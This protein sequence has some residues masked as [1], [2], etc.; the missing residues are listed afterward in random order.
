[1]NNILELKNILIVDDDPTSAYLLSIILEKKGYKIRV[2]HHAGAVFNT[3]LPDLIL[4]D[5]KMPEMSG[6]ELCQQLKASEQ[7]QPIPVIFIS[8]LEETADKIKGFQVGGVDYITKPF[9]PEEVL[10]RVKTHLTISAMQKQL[11]IQNRQLQ[12]EI[13]ARQ[14]FENKLQK[15]EEHYHLLSDKL[16]VRV[17]ERIRA[18]ARANK[19]LQ[20][21]IDERKQAKKAL[22][23]SEILYRSFTDD[24]L[25][26]L[27]VGIFILDAD[28]KVV[29]INR[30]IERY[31]GL[32]REA[33]IGKDKRQLIQERIQ[34]IFVDPKKFVKKVFATYD[35]NTYVE[36]FEC[37]VLSSG[38]R[39]ERWLEH[40][41]MPIYSGIY[42]G[43]RIEQYYDITDRK[44][45]DTALLEKTAF[46][47]GILRYSINQAI[48]ATDINF[49]ITYYNP[50]AEKIFGYTAKEAIGKT[51]MEI[52]TKEKV[53]H[54]RFQRAIK[55]VQEE[56]EYHYTV[57]NEKEDGTHYVDSRVSGILDKN[58]EIIGF[59]LLSSDVTERKRNEAALRESRE[60]LHA[61]LNNSA[62][63]IFLKD[64]TG[65]YLFINKRFE[66]LFLISNEEIS[67]KTDYDFFPKENAEL[68]VSHDQEVIKSQSLLK[69]EEV[70]PQSDGLHTYLSVKFPLYDTKG[71]I[72]AVCGMA[73]DITERKKIEEELIQA[74][75]T[76][77]SASQA[78]SEFLANMSHEIRT[79]MNAIIVLTQLM[80]KTE[81]TAKQRDFLTD[82]KSS[83]QALL[84]I[85][86]DILDFSKIEAGKL[87][88]ESVN[89][90]LDN[91]LNR[92]S[93]MLGMKIEEK[94]LEL[95]ITIDTDIPH[96]LVGD[97]L[98]L[99]QILVNLTNNAIKFTENGKILIKIRILALETEKVKLH[100]S[101]Q[102]TGIGISQEIIAHL[103][104]AFTQA[105]GSTT[106]E[107]GGT[108][109]GLAI[110]K[111]LVE[112]M[113]GE[114][115]IESKL[116]KGSIFNFTTFF[117]MREN[118]VSGKN[119]GDEN[120][121]QEVDKTQEVDKLLQNLRG[122]RILLAED[123]V[124]NQKVAREILESIGLIVEIVNNGK[125]ALAAIAH[126]SGFDAILMDVQM[127]EM[128]GYEATQFIKRQ[129]R[130]C[131]IIAMTAHAMSSD[132]NKCLEAGMDD[133]VSKP[134][135]VDQ[136]FIVLTKWI[137]PKNIG[138]QEIVK[139]PISTRNFEGK[140]ASE[141]RLPDKL[142][143]IDIKSA[144]KRLSGNKKLFKTLLKDFD[145]DYQN[146]V[147]DIRAAL[148]KPDFKT[149]QNLIHT[150]KG[151]AGNISAYQLQGAARD[152]EIALKEARLE[153]EINTFIDQVE[154]ASAQLLVSIQILKDKEAETEVIDDKTEISLESLSPLLTELAELIEEGCADFEELLE[155]IKQHIKGTEF[156]SELKQLE[157][158]LDKFDFKGAKKP[159]NVIINSIRD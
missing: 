79:P 105:D 46:I 73:T 91:V 107:F 61:I 41:S 150:L 44:Q 145:R 129:H 6:F 151:V 70:F 136:L 2:V 57:I 71:D 29:W 37:H 4:L 113:G 149:A 78:K 90:N 33:I 31:F 118:Q 110:C 114:I 128:D 49:R 122:A 159:L 94:G 42:T 66:E 123:N 146:V 52:H 132:K 98:R 99:G 43:G 11:E 80:L 111:R 102:D 134:I 32:Q 39:D 56:G 54:A 58:G 7:Y 63:V 127:P 95:F 3:N 119:L 139:K 19:A 141:E 21:E 40:L 148:N 155:K 20:H 100:F 1:M 76:A 96:H 88:M 34:T 104:D 64:I 142:P 82:I 60:Q 25:E 153:D 143:G 8:G 138:F 117:G 74:K 13:F 140:N 51:V 65:H 89:F 106:R 12:Q 15:S 81:L 69:L 112:M 72:Y 10:A 68:F 97:P 24:V 109:L 103:F 115:W 125:E 14:R 130:E 5:I 101:V 131:P 87:S 18:L 135:D 67:N 53:K 35:N 23:K 30:A 9:S 17:D 86:N 62:T 92:I 133:Y 147:N 121:S 77:E 55:I 85:I 27:I 16:E 93:N 158:C 157:A 124:I 137:K 144:I 47:D 154:N 38:E 156:A 45:A 108:G 36:N 22:Q 120:I 75:E 116:G 26:N 126:K 152:L 83:S 50:I 28:F 59:L 84:S 48:A